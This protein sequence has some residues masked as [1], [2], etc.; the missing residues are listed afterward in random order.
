M[1]QT[2]DIRQIRLVRPASSCRRAA[3]D[4]LPLSIFG[5]ETIPE[6]KEIVTTLENDEGV[7]GRHLQRRG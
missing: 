5:P 1:S 7:K 2:P 4:N 3:F 6:L